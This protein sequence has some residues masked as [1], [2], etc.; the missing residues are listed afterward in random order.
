M[1]S[2]KKEQPSRPRGRPRAY[3]PERALSRATD[4]FWRAGYSATSVDDLADATAMNRPSLY[5]AFGNKHALYLKTLE[6]Y[7]AAGREAMEE[8]LDESLSLREGLMRVYE[9]ALSL[10]FPR[11]GPARGCFLIST[12]ATEAVADLDVRA[13]LR[14]GLREFDRAFEA[15]IRH[16]REQ[17]ELEASADPAAL[18]AIASAIMHTLALRSRAGDSAGSLRATA[19][20]GVDLI[21]GPTSR[22]TPKASRPK[23]RPSPRSR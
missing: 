21:C 18:A 8:A 2:A 4:A 11:Q 3:D 17:G 5:G 22:K 9:G 6:R 19:A 23:R 13:A 16:A 15:R 20:A 7:I 14:G 10:Y 1:E 12:A